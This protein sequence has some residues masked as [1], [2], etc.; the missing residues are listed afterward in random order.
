MLHILQ[1]YVS[2]VLGVSNV[3]SRCCICL[4]WL[5]T[6][7]SS[8]FQVFQM[9]Q[10]HVA[11]VDLDVAKS[12]SRCYIYVAMAIYTCFKRIFQVFHLN[13]SKVDLGEDIFQ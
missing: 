8:V 13:I 6:H 9:F 2:S 7:V 11:K 1:A 5:Y 12:R 3:L 10:T 4:L